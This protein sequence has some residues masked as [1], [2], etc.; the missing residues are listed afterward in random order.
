MRLTY[1][2][3]VVNHNSHGVDT[4]KYGAGPEVSRNPS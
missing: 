4:S 3:N 1:R 2:F